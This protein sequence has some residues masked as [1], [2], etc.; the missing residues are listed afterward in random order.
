MARACEMKSPKEDKEEMALLKIILA[1]L[2]AKGLADDDWNE[3]DIYEA[4]NKE[5]KYRR[6]HI[7]KKEIGHITNQTMETEGF[8]YVA[9]FC[10]MCLGLFIFVVRAHICP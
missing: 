4:A 1:K 5:M 8:L 7:D 3:D 6:Y 2:E 10:V 9:L